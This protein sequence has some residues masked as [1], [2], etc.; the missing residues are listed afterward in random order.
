MLNLR[1]SSATNAMSLSDDGENGNKNVL[2]Y[3]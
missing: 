3:L 1:V 2:Y